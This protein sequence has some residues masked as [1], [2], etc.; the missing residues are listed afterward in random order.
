MKILHRAWLSAVLL[1]LASLLLY[2]INIER[3]P[4]H[5]ELYHILAA[6][7]LLATGEPSIGEAGL[8]WRGYPV[9]WLVAQSFALFEPGLTAA[10]LPAVLFMAGLVVL[11]FLF[12][13]REAGALAAWLG[14]GLFAISP[15]AIELAQFVRFYSLQTLLFFAAA[16]IVYTLVGST[17]STTRHLPLAGLA[18]LLLGVAYNLQP[19]TLLGVVGL[20]LWA[21]GAVFLPWLADPLVPGRRKQSAF[22]ALIAAGLALTAMI[23]AT[24][25]LADIWQTYRSTALFNRQ[26]ADQFWYYHGWYTLLYPTLWTTSGLLAIAALIARPRLASFLLVVFIT[27]FLL[28]SFAASKNMR[29]ISYAQPFLFGFWGL[30]LS[31]LLL[32]A[33]PLYDRSRAWLGQS[34]TLLPVTIARSLAT[35]L[36]IGALAFLVVTN[37]ASLRTVALLAGLT[38]PPT[39]PPNDWPAAQPV[40]DPWI[41]RVGAVVTTDELR[42]LYHYGRAD[43]LLS[44]TKFAEL[45]ETRRQP[46][47]RDI[48]TDVPVIADARSLEL[49]MQCHDSGLFIAQVLRLGD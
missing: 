9:T 49:I 26:H 20:A 23:W 2:T 41:E 29:Y 13:H 17:W 8:Y 11:L 32:G 39:L 30:S 1:G 28:N 22:L 27:G 18:L 24:G 12:L 6:E 33:G 25:I 46:F 14:A 15:F 37:P 47:G 42:M 10:R 7:G 16:W 40:L 31:V 19:T 3:A 5:D 35:L 43:Y 44:A 34:L 36:V 48:R 21:T 4:H 38:V 45:P